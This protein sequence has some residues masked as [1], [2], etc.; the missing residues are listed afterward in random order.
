MRDPA[1]V[2]PP[3]AGGAGDAEPA[4]AIDLTPDDGLPSPPV[5]QNLEFKALADSPDAI[6]DACVRLG[7]TLKKSGRQV[8]TYFE[9]HRGRLKLRE[10]PT[11][12]SLIFYE[13][14]DSPGLRESNFRLIP[15]DGKEED[16]REALTRGLGVR[17]VVDKRREVFVYGSSLINVDTLAGIGDFVEIETN[18]RGAGGHEQA[19]VE[20]KFLRESLGISQADVVPWSYS[21]LLALH[22]AA[23]NSREILAQT[24]APGTLFLL[25][26]PSCSGKTTIV[27][28]LADD[29]EIRC[30]L[31]PRHSTRQPR[32]DLPSET[33]YLFVSAEEFAQMAATGQFLEYRDFLF[34]M[35]Y[36]LSWK[37]ILNTLTQGRNAVGI[38][39]LGNGRYVKRL[40]P[41][42]V[43]IM[44]MAPVSTIRRRLIARGLNTPDQIEERIQNAL[45]AEAYAPY[46]DHPVINDDGMYDH[47][48]RQVKS[49]I[50]ARM[51]HGKTT[52]E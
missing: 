19:L 2:R 11:G 36:G 33:E 29:G 51:A 26:G 23:R 43:T 12:A 1:A 42:A 37:L 20:A 31:I 17:S 24:A 47:A 50:A 45:T 3:R 8:D 34:G 35:S 10:N 46:Y 38:I 6:R 48:Y 25:D 27:H 30:E 5:D 14:L 16:F 21:D 40:F 13:R 49:I 15:V 39:N 52:G 32:A 22:Q 44:V 4:G 9:V 18:V 41:E 28:Q 7:A